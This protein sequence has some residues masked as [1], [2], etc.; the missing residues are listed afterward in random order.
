[1]IS[2]EESRAVNAL[3]SIAASHDRSTRHSEELVIRLEKMQPK[4]YTQVFKDFNEVFRD[5]VSALHQLGIHR[6]AAEKIQDSQ[7]G[8]SK[9]IYYAN[10][11]HNVWVSPN[12]NVSIIIRRMKY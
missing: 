3:E 10:E 6:D 9:C 8:I 1:M 5:I 12:S 2:S 4:D 7:R 11:V